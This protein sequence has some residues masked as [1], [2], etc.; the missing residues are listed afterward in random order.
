M[1]TIGCFLVI[2]IMELRLYLFIYLFKWKSLGCRHSLPQSGSVFWN[3]TP[4]PPSTIWGCPSPHP[5]PHALLRDCQP[6]TWASPVY[7][8]ALFLPHKGPIS[9]LEVLSHKLAKCHG[10]P[11]PSCRIFQILSPSQLTCLL[12]DPRPI[13]P[14][15]TWRGSP[16]CVP[17]STPHPRPGM[18]S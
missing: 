17:Q 13:C 7:H 9:S 4:L 2:D 6:L 15:L 5:F 8:A 10:G 14:D 1:W 11:P 16:L 3:T 18:L 12:L